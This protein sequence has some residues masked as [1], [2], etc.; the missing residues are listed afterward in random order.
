M[1]YISFFLFSII[2]CAS[3]TS[4]VE[5]AKAS[6]MGVWKVRM[7]S[8]YTPSTGLSEE[9]KSGVGEFEFTENNCDYTFN[10]ANV[11]EENNFEYTFE[12]SKENAGFTSI[13]RFDIKGE[14]NYRVRFGDQTS[15]SHK[16]ASEMTL[17]RTIDNDSTVFEYIISLVKI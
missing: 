7:V 11:N 2:F 16:D 6:L 8:K 9:D 1:R 15:D 4:T 17:E 3:C 5:S 12:V 13:D 10:F 14:E